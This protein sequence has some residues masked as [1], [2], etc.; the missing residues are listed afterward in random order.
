MEFLFFFSFVRKKK[1]TTSGTRIEVGFFN[2]QSGEGRRGL[3]LKDLS[4]QIS[5]IFLL[6]TPKH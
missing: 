4:A 2:Y 1:N 6:T 3:F 5:F